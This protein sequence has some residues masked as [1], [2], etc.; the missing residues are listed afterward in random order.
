MNARRIRLVSNSLNWLAQQ[1]IVLKHTRDELMRFVISYRIPIEIVRH[2]EF[3]DIGRNTA[4]RI[5][6]SRTVKRSA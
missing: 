2:V 5:H 1:G 6:A 3:P 4:L